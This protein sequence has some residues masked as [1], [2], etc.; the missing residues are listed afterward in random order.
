MPLSSNHL[1]LLRELACDIE[2]FNPETPRHS[3]ELYLKD[4]N[5]ALSYLP[6]ITMTDK[7]FLW[8]KTTTRAFHSFI[9]RPVQQS[10]MITM[11]RENP[12]Q[13]SLLCMKTH[14]PLVCQLLKSSKAATSV[15]ESTMII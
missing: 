14:I 2:V 6:D 10:L 9:E 13:Q 15:L 11:N 4:V 1:S 5:F 12:L 3:I 7:L 8:M